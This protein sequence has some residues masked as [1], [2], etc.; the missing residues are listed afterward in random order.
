LPRRAFPSM[1]AAMT[2]IFS[3][4][5]FAIRAFMRVDLWSIVIPR[6]RPLGG[7]PDDYEHCLA[8]PAA[9]SSGFGSALYV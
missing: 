7:R 4:F 2:W 6:R 9:R 8:P 5:A 3:S 1:W